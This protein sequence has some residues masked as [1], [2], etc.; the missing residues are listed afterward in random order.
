MRLSAAGHRPAGAAAQGHHC[1]RPAR[2]DTHPRA[3]E[4]RFRVPLRQHLGLAR[5]RDVCCMTGGERP[6]L[7]DHADDGRR[8]AA[9]SLSPSVMPNKEGRRHSWRPKACRAREQHCRRFLTLRSSH[10]WSAA[11]GA[12]PPPPLAQHS[13]SWAEAQIASVLRRIPDFAGLDDENSVRLCE[14]N[15]QGTDSH[16]RPGTNKSNE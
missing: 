13:P 5:V 10:I 2:R 14:S 6:L 1:A 7:T 16:S 4:A 11:S 8:P 12:C 3:A 15:P 9:T